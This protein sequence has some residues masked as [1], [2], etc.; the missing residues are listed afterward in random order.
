MT[1][2][3][4]WLVVKP[5]VGLPVFLFTVALTALA[6][7]AA[8]LANGRLTAWWSEVPLAKPAAVA[9]QAAPAPVAAP[10]A[11]VK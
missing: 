6:I 10:A 8:L 4:I 1:N 2:G 11:D 9:V 5:T 7:H 3:K